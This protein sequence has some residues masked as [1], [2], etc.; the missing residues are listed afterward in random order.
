[1]PKYKQ[2]NKHSLFL[3][4][5]IKDEKKLPFLNNKVL[6]KY[7]E[8]PS[9]TSRATID[10]LPIDLIQ[11]IMQ[12]FLR[13]PEVLQ[14][15][16]MVSTRLLS[17]IMQP[18]RLG[19]GKD[20]NNNSETWYPFLQMIFE[21][22]RPHHMNVRGVSFLD[23]LSKLKDTK[24]SSINDSDR[25]EIAKISSDLFL[26]RIDHLLNFDQQTELHEW[27]ISK[28]QHRSVINQ[29]KA[30]TSPLNLFCVIFLLL[31]GIGSLIGGSIMWMKV[32]DAEGLH[33]AGLIAGSLISL[34]VCMSLFCGGACTIP[35]M[36]ADGP[37]Q[38]RITAE[39]RALKDLRSNNPFKVDEST[40]IDVNDSDSEL[41]DKTPLLFSRR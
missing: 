17:A 30:I 36:I 35:F 18:Q 34:F 25:Q 14:K 24:V 2:A 13:E 15:L 11:L 33:E 31:V 23:Y 9:P 1:M 32:R 8:M 38:N 19:N 20:N 4:S 28:Y 26:R 27:N 40:I 3:F 12:Q 37:T 41:N 5:P 16:S 21:T 6:R 7:R 10:N 29:D 22:R 39:K